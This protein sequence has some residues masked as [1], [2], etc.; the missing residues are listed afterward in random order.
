MLSL[1]ASNGHS[2]FAQMGTFAIAFATVLTVVLL[3]T[4]GLGMHLSFPLSVNSSSEDRYRR[5]V[6]GLLSASGKQLAE[7]NVRIADTP[8]KLYLGLSGLESLA[9]REGMLFVYGSSGTHVYVMRNMKFPIDI[10][11]IATNGCITAIRR[12]TLPP[13][14]TEISDL[15][16]YRGR[17]QYVLEVPLG[18]ASEI[19][20]S[21]GDYVKIPVSIKLIAFMKRVRKYFRKMYQSFFL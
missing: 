17:G 7:I 16:R 9:P 3:A 1:H 10:V 13:D 2:E 15:T 19:G 6:V 14:R 20:L 18:V 4:I 12:A 11:F 5:A 21:K 8:R